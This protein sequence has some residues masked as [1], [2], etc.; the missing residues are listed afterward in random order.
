MGGGKLDLSCCKLIQVPD[1][2][3]IIIEERNIEVTACN[4]SS[5]V[6][7]KIP[8]KLPSKFSLITDLNL[9]FNK[10]SALPEELSKCS[11]LETV[12]IS[13]NLF[14]SLPTCLL[15]HVIL[16]DMII[17]FG[18]LHIYF[19][20]DNRYETARLVDDLKGAEQVDSWAFLVGVA[21]ELG[22]QFLVAGKSDT[23]NLLVFVVEQ[24]VVG[25]IKVSDAL[26]G[27][28]VDAVNPEFGQTNGT[29][30]VYVNRFESFVNECFKCCGQFSKWFVH[31]IFWTASANSFPSTSPSLLKSAN[32]A[33]SFHKLAMTSWFFLKVASFQSPLPSMTV[34]RTA[35]H[36][37]SL[38]SKVPF[39][40]MSYMYLTTNFT[41]LSQE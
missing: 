31:T 30:T 14:V 8:P 26:V 36:S 40:S 17:L 13:N 4:L 23:S 34:L 16:D 3:Y 1:A 38:L 28:P 9:S 5:N 27:H 6:I 22:V 20:H 25:G 10:L 37:K 32:S 7:K 15:D 29:V 11:Q 12:D 39:P 21:D 35:K 2:L 33:I 24:R 19:F 18:F 41:R